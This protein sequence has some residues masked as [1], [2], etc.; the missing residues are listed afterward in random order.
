MSQHIS[1]DRVLKWCNF[2]TKNKA[3]FV[4]NSNQEMIG[5]CMI[6]AILDV[7]SAV[8]AL[9]CWGR[10][11]VGGGSEIPPHKN[12]KKKSSFKAGAHR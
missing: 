9:G 11:K 3:N 12:K 7:K 2:F 6:A 1:Q 8:C 5:P 4:N 10:E